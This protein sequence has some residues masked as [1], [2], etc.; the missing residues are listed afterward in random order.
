ME[1]RGERD[2]C[3]M[4]AGDGE[5]GAKARGGG[6]GTAGWEKREHEAP[7]RAMSGPEVRGAKPMA[8]H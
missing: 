2:M 1:N 5:V 8:G 6:A 4:G 3:G 7:F